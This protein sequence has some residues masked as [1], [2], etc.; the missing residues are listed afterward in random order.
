MNST[1]YTMRKDGTSLMSHGSLGAAMDEM[2]LGM[3]MFLGSGTEAMRV[4]AALGKS[5]TENK[6]AARSVEPGTL[7]HIG[8]EGGSSNDNDR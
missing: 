8:M 2:S 1:F 4:A 3:I 5:A 7:L 6:W